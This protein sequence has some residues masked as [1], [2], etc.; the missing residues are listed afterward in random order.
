M[1]SV[2]CPRCGSRNL[3]RLAEGNLKCNDCGYVGNSTGK[4]IF[5]K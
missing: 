4:E 3:V 2:F 1:K 5:K